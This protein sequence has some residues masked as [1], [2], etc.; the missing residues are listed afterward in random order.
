[1]KKGTNASQSQSEPGYQYMEFYQDN[2][3]P[4]V[5]VVPHKISPSGDPYAVPAKKVGPGI[6]TNTRFA[7]SRMSKKWVLNVLVLGL[8]GALRQSHGPKAGELKK[9]KWCTRLNPGFVFEHFWL[10]LGY[11]FT[12][13]KV[14]CHRRWQIFHVTLEF[15]TCHFN[16]F[17]LCIYSTYTQWSWIFVMSWD[18][19]RSGE[20]L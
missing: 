6:Y 4:E 18:I 16:I 20:T 7:I 19:C 3:T 2:Q 14:K 8:T 15:V 13:L 1:M 11:F 5:V 9:K 10:F 17:F 12:S